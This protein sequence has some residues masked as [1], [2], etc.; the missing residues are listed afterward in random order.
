MICLVYK[1]AICSNRLTGV[2]QRIVSWLKVISG[3]KFRGFACRVACCIIQFGPSI[4]CR[5]VVYRALFSMNRPLWPVQCG[6]RGCG[7]AV[8]ECHESTYL[9][10]TCKNKSY[11]EGYL[12]QIDGKEGFEFTTR[13]VKYLKGKLLPAGRRV[14]KMCVRK[15]LHINMYTHTDKHIIMLRKHVCI[16]VVWYSSCTSWPL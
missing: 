6:V 5:Q 13:G 12:T 11:H 9:K 10:V 8:S 3:L 7:G 14:P 15:S 1:C 4:V 2:V 16:S